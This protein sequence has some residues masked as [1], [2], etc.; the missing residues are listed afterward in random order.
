MLRRREE[1]TPLSRDTNHSKRERTPLVTL[2]VASANRRRDVRDLL[3][4]RL[5]EESPLPAP[6]GH[7]PERHENSQ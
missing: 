1:V 4:G 6:D 5:T 3:S 7:D 2:L